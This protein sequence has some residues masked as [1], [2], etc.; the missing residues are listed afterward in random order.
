M[1]GRRL[2]RLSEQCNQALTTASL[3]GRK[4]DFK[5]LNRLSQDGKEGQMLEALE[6]ALA[7]RDRELRPYA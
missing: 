5:L 3:I 6:E 2:N 4:F 1:I 7:A